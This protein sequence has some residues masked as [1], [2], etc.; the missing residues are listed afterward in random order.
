MSLGQCLDAQTGEWR[1]VRPSDLWPDVLISIAE[2]ARDVCEEHRE[3]EREEK[4]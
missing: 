4:S 2:V 1:D 3:L